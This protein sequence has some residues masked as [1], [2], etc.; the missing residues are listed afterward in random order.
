[1]AGSY[2]QPVPFTDLSQYVSGSGRRAHFYTELTISSETVSESITSA[3]CTYPQR[4]G[5]AEWA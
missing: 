5:Q 4:D 3:H 1:M 2:L